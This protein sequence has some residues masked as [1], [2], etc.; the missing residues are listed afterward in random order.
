MK[1]AVVTWVDAVGSNE[2]QALPSGSIPVLPTVLTCGWVMTEDKEGIW[3]ASTFGN[4]LVG[5]TMLIPRGMVK[6]V[7][8]VGKRYD[9]P[10]A[11]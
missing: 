10:D 3:L 7:S 8:Y 2:W 9:I 1:L 4:G 5:Q 6:K 11:G